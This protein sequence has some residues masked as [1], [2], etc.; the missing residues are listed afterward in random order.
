MPTAPK[1]AN[2]GQSTPRIRRL[3]RTLNASGSSRVLRRSAMTETCAIVNESIAPNAYMLPRKSVLP[4]R[5]TTIES[6]PAKNRSDNHG[7]LNFGWSRRKT[8]GSCR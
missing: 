2:S 8:S 7:V 5:S 1:I 6:S 3:G 4:G